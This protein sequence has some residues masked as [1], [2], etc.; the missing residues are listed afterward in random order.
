MEV[1]IELGEA[2]AHRRCCEFQQRGFFATRGG[3]P[4][5]ISPLVPTLNLDICFSKPQ[6]M[7]LRVSK[8]KNYCLHAFWFNHFPVK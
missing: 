4:G 7:L 5:A 2:G 8:I 6:W 3:P 1:E